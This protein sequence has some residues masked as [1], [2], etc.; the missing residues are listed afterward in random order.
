MTNRNGG[1]LPEVVIAN[2]GHGMLK[3]LIR[4]IGQDAVIL[5]P[6]MNHD[7]EPP[8]WTGVWE[9]VT[10]VEVQTVIWH[11]ELVRMEADGE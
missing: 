5:R 9:R 11:G 1:L 4:L 2:V 8:C 3:H 7:V 10:A 6:V